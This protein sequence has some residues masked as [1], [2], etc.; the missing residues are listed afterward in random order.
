MLDR[1]MDTLVRDLPAPHNKRDHRASASPN[2][3]RIAALRR[4]VETGQTLP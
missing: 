1:M 3:G 4:T 2:T